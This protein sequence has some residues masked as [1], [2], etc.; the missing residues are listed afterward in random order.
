MH[1]SFTFAISIFYL[2]E[3]CYQYIVSKWIEKGSIDLYLLLYIDKLNN[4]ASWQSYFVSSERKIVFKIDSYKCECTFAFILNQ[5][6]RQSIKTFS[7]RLT[8]ERFKRFIPRQQQ[9]WTINRWW[10]IN[11]KCWTKTKKLLKKVVFIRPCT[12]SNKLFD[13]F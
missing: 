2:F 7:E 10:S 5:P 12:Y 11:R 9:R 13:I 3:F 6:S 1:F 4:C 8:T